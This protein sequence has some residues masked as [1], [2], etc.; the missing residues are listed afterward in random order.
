ML[1]LLLALQLSS[2]LAFPPAVL[3]VAR[4]MSESTE[5][6]AAIAKFE[7]ARLE[8]EKNL[9]SK[10]SEIQVLIEKKAAA[11]TVERT[12]V[13]LKRLTE[14]AEVQLTE[15]ERALQV[16]FFKKVEPLVIQIVN[17]D[18]LG[19]LFTL[20]NPLIVWTGPSV[21]IT[22]KVI[23]RLDAAIKNSLK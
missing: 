21:D 2:E 6:K 14:D 10:R 8:R 3:N 15:L 11:A 22:T 12:Q 9:S 1:A 16:D 4:V 7:A 5:G 17:E 13:E 20:P 23:Q 18:K 19:I